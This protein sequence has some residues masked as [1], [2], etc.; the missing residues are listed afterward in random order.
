MKTRN[1]LSSW[2][3]RLVWL[4]RSKVHERL[5]VN[6]C[7]L[8]LSCGRHNIWI[9]SDFQV[10]QFSTRID[11]LHQFPHTWGILFFSFDGF[12][13]C[14]QGWL[15][16]GYLVGVPKRGILWYTH[17]HLGS[18]PSFTKP[19][20]LILEHDKLDRVFSIIKAHIVVIMLLTPATQSSASLNLISTSAL[21][22]STCAWSLSTPR[23]CALALSEAM[24][25]S[26]VVAST[27]S[28]RALSLFASF[29]AS[30]SSS[31]TM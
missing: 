27:M 28:F 23:A 8:G 11:G 3:L 31:S 14:G 4:N 10:N 22:C 7:R 21:Y 18:Q 9:A 15:W 30:F 12:L 6:I 25:F 16:V 19:I 20:L 29:T 13:S 5:N 26:L 17:S 2:I 1:R 24:T